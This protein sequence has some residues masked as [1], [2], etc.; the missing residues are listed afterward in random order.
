MTKQIKLSSLLLLF[1]VYALAQ[2]SETTPLPKWEIVA[3]GTPVFNDDSF[4]EQDGARFSLQV[5]KIIN[6]NLSIGLRPSYEFHGHRAIRGAL[7][8]YGKYRKWVNPKTNWFVQSEVGYGFEERYSVQFSSFGIGQD[9]RITR[10][11][12]GLYWETRID[13][14]IGLEFHLFKGIQGLLVLNSGQGIEM[15]L[16]KTI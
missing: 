6:R 7:Q 5:G 14:G 16:R 12:Q 1:A 10:Q 3:L 2:A 15:G 9:P 13:F 11:H 8:V 4:D